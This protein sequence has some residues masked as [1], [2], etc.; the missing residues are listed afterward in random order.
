M[1]TKGA[2]VRG[3]ERKKKLVI[4]TGANGSLGKAYLEKLRGV[5]DIECLGIV[6][7]NPDKPNEDESVVEAD[8]LD[9]AAVAEQIARIDLSTISE[10][11]FIHPVG[12]FRFEKSG[13]PN[14]DKDKDGID[15]EVYRSNVETF[16]NVVNPLLTKLSEQAALGNPIP[17]KLCAFGSI[18]DRYEVPYWQ[19]Y[20]KAKEILRKFI[21]SLV[22]HK[23][24]GLVRGLLINLSSV[25]T[26]NERKMRPNADRTYWLKCDEIV[27]QTLPFLLEQGVF[28][29]E[30]DVFKPDPSFDPDY[31]RDLKKILKKWLRETV[32]HGW[33]EL[34]RR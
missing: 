26:E 12:K 25:D 13:K 6:R 20:S 3:M 29:Q 10:V 17:L 18:S 23:P 5:P 4:I 22:G 31:Y 8:L 19:S 27:E 9:E 34:K 2:S 1:S 14:N 30:V 21:R 24:N 16:Y 32:F 7:P 28:W 11:I 33:S 15:D